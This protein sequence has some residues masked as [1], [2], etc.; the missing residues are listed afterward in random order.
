MPDP[1]A[2]NP[3]ADGLVGGCTI[4]PSPILPGANYRFADGQILS[5]SAYSLLYSRY[6]TAHN[7]GG[8]TADEFRLPNLNGRV[9][10]GRDT[11]DA[12]LD[13]VGET[14][15]AKA[16]TMPAHGHGLTGSPAL[17]TLAVN[18]ASHTHQGYD[19]SP[20]AAAGAATWGWNL[21]G[22]SSTA[23]S[24]AVAGAGG[25][26]TLAVGDAAGSGDNMPPFVVT[27]YI[28]KVL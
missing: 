24:L 26:G 16:A 9:P 2:A 18:P 8:E 11:G 5:R 23:A 21:S 6:G 1:V 14:G 28:I 10:V 7:T 17:G 25:I 20:S 3:D 15:G 22:A 4:W 27:N 13:T 19:F 12:Q